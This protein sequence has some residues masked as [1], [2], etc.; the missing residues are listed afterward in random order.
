M[1]AAAAMESDNTVSPQLVVPQ[2]SAAK[3]ITPRHRNGSRLLLG[4]IAALSSALIAALAALVALV[5]ST[6]SAPPPGSVRPGSDW[7]GASPLSLA[8]PDAA[9][10]LTWFAH[11]SCAHQKKPQAFW[12][13][14]IGLAPQVF[15]FNGDIVYGDCSN[16]SYCG[17]LPT[18]WRDLFGNANFQAATR[19]L[20]MM[21]IL[22]DHD[23]G[24]N[25]GHRGVPEYESWK[26]YAKELFMERFGVPSSDERRFREGLYTHRTFGPTGKRTQVVILDTRWFRS[27]FLD[28]PCPSCPGR[29]RYVPYN[30]SDRAP[31]LTMLGETQWR[32]LEGVLREPAELRILVSTIQVLAMDHGWERWGLI[33]S[34]VA[35]L[36]TLINATRAEGLVVISGDRHMGGLYR[37][38]AGDARPFGV[39]APFPIYEVTSSSLT[40]TVRTAEAEAFTLRLGSLTHENNFGT[41]RVDWEARKVTLDLRASD[42]CGLS[43]QPWA[44]VC[45]AHDG[46][47]SRVL[48]NLTIGLEALQMQA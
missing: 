40:H 36:L 35:R 7:F 16:S 38:E 6:A 28:T 2:L 20:P 47:A 32:W 37:L 21:G 18:A 5:A 41:V 17:E 26:A 25:D 33:P 34:E 22:D 43:E 19:A 9:S 45:K 30:Q 48:M 3:Q 11:G 42:D 13:T 23:Y 24:V 29:E 46:E 8:L 14:L 10:A 15:L 12:R 4:C 39:P 44:Q 31:S 1:T 27:K